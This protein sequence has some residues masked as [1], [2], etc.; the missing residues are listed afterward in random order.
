MPATDPNNPFL[1]ERA[2]IVGARM[3]NPQVKTFRVIF[4]DPARMAGFSFAPGQVA[5]ISAFGAGE[6]TFVINS[7]PTRPEYLQFSVMLAGEVTR[8]LHVLKEGARIGLRAPLGNGFDMAVFKGKNVVLVAGG[9]GMAPLRP[10]LLTML[11]NRA[12]YGDILLIYGTRGPED[13]CFKDDLSAWRE[14]GD[15]AVVETIDNACTL[16]TRCVGLVPN[17]LLEKKPSPEGAVAVCCGPPIMIRY[18]LKA[19]GELGFTDEQIVTTLERRMKCGIGLCGRCNIGE[20]YVCVDG[21]VFTL[22]EL[23]KLPPEL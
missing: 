18:T 9:L 4:E 16:W 3:E 15:M 12:D 13:F 8:R 11:D 7:P 17:V 6:A 14:R 23:K 21:P 20:K 5:Q 2:L 1:P 10:L 22:S 19:L